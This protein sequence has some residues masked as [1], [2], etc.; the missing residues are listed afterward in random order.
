[1]VDKLK[2]LTKKELIELVKKGGAR[3]SEPASRSKPAPAPVAKVPQKHPAPPKGSG[4]IV[5]G[6][7]GK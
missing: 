5:P 3:A 6:T 2:R 1:M 4:R 7:W